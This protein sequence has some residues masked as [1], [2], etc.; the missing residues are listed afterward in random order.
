MLLFYLLFFVLGAS[1]GS[2]LNAME[3]RLGQAVSLGGRSLCPQCRKKIKWYDNIPILSFLILRGRCRFCGG[4]ISWQYPAVELLIALGW[5]AIVVYATPEMGLPNLLIT[6][7]QCFIFWIFAFIFIF[8]LKYGEVLDSFTLIPA[9]L[10][11]LLSIAFG[12]NSWQNILVAMAIGG[13]FFAVQYFISKGKWIGGGDI[14]IGILMGAILGWPNILAALI[15]AYVGGAIV[16]LGFLAVKKK[17]LS[18]ST[19]F[20]TYLSVATIL[21]FF[22]G[23]GLVNWYLSLIN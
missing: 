17:T 3:W 23:D 7:Y 12:W 4:R 14:R 16:S 2:F 13:G 20:G 19:P 22:A 10:S 18:D 5:T 6:A 21:I 15:L 11:V 9:V 8:D 1:F